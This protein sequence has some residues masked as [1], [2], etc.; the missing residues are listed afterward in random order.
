MTTEDAI[1]YAARSAMRAAAEL[2]EALTRHAE[3]VTGVPS[4]D[5]P[6]DADFEAKMAHYEAIKDQHNDA[7]DKGLDLAIRTVARATGVDPKAM[8][9]DGVDPF[10]LRGVHLLG[11]VMTEATD[12]IDECMLTTHAARIKAVFSPSSH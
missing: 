10:V 12:L 6:A 8:A 1:T 4:T 5:P 2:L 11:A 9:A 7:L 3:R